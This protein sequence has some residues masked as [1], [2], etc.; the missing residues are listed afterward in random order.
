ME[1]RAVV[2][3][4][5]S[6]VLALAALSV[7]AV[8][9]PGL[10]PSYRDEIVADGPTGYWRFGETSGTVAADETANAVRG[11]YQNGVV[12][13][14]PGALA[15]DPNAAARF[16]GGNDK[17]TFGDPASGILDFGTED[18]SVEAWV[19]TSVNDERAII[20]KRDATRYWQVTVTDDGSQ[21][22]R[23]RANVFDGTV[24]RQVYS[25]HRV[26]DG[27]W[28]HVV[29][30]FDRDSG[31]RFYTDGLPS[32][33]T[34]APMPGD[35]GNTA[36]LLVGKVSGYAE[37]KGD[38]DEVAVYRGL[39]PAERVE[40]H[41]HAAANDTT[42]PAVTLTSPAAGSSTT[43]TT[44]AFS[45]TAG[46]AVGD[47]TT[48]AV[49]VYPGA[50]AS[51]PPV[52][53]LVATRAAD[54]SYSVA[55]SELALGEYTAQAAQTDRT[56]NVG[57]SEISTF[58]VVDGAPPPPP[59]PG[60]PVFVGAGDIASC[61]DG[62]GDE[63]TAA[64]LDAMPE[65]V[66]YTTG[67]NAYPDGTTEQFACYDASWGRAKAR[68]HPSVG[69]HEYK[70]PGAAGYF[71]Y[72]GAAAGDPTQ[73]Y[74]SYDL[75][76]WHIVVLNSECVEIGGCG[77]GSPQE[78]W[79]RTDLA[80]HPSDCTLAYWH[81]P[82]FSSGAEHG[83][84]PGIAPFWD[85]LYDYGAD[86][87][88]N[89]HEHLY[90]RFLPQTSGGVLDLA[91]GMTQFTVG[92]GGFGLYGW[93]AAQPNSI[94][95]IND[96]YG[97]LKLVL[98]AD[99]YD[100]QFIAASG[101]S[102][103]DE[104]SASC[105]GSAAP[106]PPPP[107]PPPPA[108]A[109]MYAGEVLSIPPRAY[110]RL[111]EVSGTVAAEEM[112]VG[113]G[114][115]Q[116]GVILGVPGALAGDS[117][118]AVR[119]D[120][121]NDRITVGDPADGSLDLGEEDFTVEAWIKP[122]ANDERAIITKRSSLGPYW[123]VT[124]TDDSNHAGQLRA[125]IFDGS[126]SLQAYSTRRVDDGAWRHVA[127]QFDRHFGIRFYVDGVAAGSA[128]GPVTGDV[129]NDGAL[130]LGKGPG[131]PEYKGELDEVALYL[132]VLSEATIADHHAVGRGSG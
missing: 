69:G 46:M 6:A 132:G 34:A 82:R 53:T 128:A 89:G 20:G 56:E 71:G 70:T 13:G 103:T 61:G 16:D 93:K 3:V 17:V 45:G 62:G 47:S 4:T 94:A 118:T 88:L 19:K 39:L 114:T 30:L 110:W 2:R 54:G 23:V 63:A 15:T 8:S 32:G 52:Q 102:S 106:P 67:D 100:W 31:V 22:G 79:L 126:V 72:F 81:I 43:S 37:F 24:S 50:G 124:V 99:G 36:P 68:T 84:N 28:H 25:L 26:D 111:G 105:H 119:L 35:L 95:R 21:I 18:F 107:P 120:G 122:S 73:G 49:S 117:N 65:A 64:L 129:S 51:G 60:D 80:E 113:S 55:G 125:N 48:V 112:G 85:A 74:Y 12:L 75:G 127:V 121:G 109:G 66:V 86:V 5:V 92:T 116:N 57:V 1:R 123:Q 41:F 33:F 83:N 7:G 97:V 27:A 130:I 115:Y 59:P 104:G 101:S 96:T 78:R 76:T 131:Y 29:V 40:A 11:T 90:E 87:I 91:Y 9:A 108:G 44:P 38:I 77:S 98:R 14:V 10:A 42:P 58:T